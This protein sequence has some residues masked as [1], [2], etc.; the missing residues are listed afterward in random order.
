MREAFRSGRSLFFDENSESQFFNSE[1]WE[2]AGVPAAVLFE[3]LLRGG[4]ADRRAR[5]RL[6]Q[7]G[8]SRRVAATTIALLA[9]EVAAVIERADMLTQL[10]DMASTDALT[11]P[12]Q[13]PRLGDTPRRDARQR[14]A[15]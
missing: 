6:A 5:R 7:G 15:A 4:R 9:H 14:P 1:I 11:G 3:P 13:P 10:A 8:Q 2:L 12:A